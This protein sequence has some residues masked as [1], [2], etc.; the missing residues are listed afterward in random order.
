M[1]DLNKM[2]G[3]LLAGSVRFGFYEI[4]KR[5]LSNTQGEKWGERLRWLNSGV[6]ADIAEFLAAGVAFLFTGRKIIQN[7]EI[8]ENAVEENSENVSP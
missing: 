6:A 7:S 5:F 3:N 2:I 4:L 1:L 8:S